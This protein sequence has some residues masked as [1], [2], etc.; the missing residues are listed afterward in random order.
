M[1][2][3]ELPKIVCNS[4]IALKKNSQLF[5]CFFLLSLKILKGIK[6]FLVGNGITENQSVFN[7]KTSLM[8]GSFA[9]MHSHD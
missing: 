2:Y 5:Q 7:I 6:G 9:I 4:A 3:G 1:F 8:L